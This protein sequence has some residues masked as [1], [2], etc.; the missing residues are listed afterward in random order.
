MAL[1]LALICFRSGDLQIDSGPRPI[2][3]CRLPCSFTRPPPLS[4]VPPSLAYGDKGLCL[5]VRDENGACP[6]PLLVPPNEKLQYELTLMR[7][8]LDP[9]RL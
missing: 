7:V 5:S 2:R 6:E 3:R 1:P 4:Q 9:A 8:A